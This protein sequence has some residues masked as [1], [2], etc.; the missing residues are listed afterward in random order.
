MRSGFAPAYRL[1]WDVRDRKVD[2][3]LL[4]RTVAEFRQSEPLLLG[5]FYPLAAWSLAKDVWAAW[6]YDRPEQGQ[7]LVQAFRRADSPYEM[8]RF[9]LRGLEASGRYAVT[10]LDKPETPQQ[11]SGRELMERGLPITLPAP[12]S[13]AVL[14]Y[15]RAASE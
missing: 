1:G 4:R 10:D 7:G 15:R 11:F 2:L 5:D 3:A 13:S 6:Q 8:A 9:R 12:R 14:T